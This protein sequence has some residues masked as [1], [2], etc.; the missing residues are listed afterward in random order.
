MHPEHVPGAD[1]VAWSLG[2]TTRILALGSVPLSIEMLPCCHGSA[3]LIQSATCSSLRVAAQRSCS[4]A[5]ELQPAD[6]SIQQPLKHITKEQTMQFFA[7]SVCRDEGVLDQPLDTMKRLMAQWV[8]HAGAEVE[9][10]TRITKKS[11]CHLSWTF[12]EAPMLAVRAAREH[13]TLFEEETELAEHE[14]EEE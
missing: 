4:C 10:T 7:E 2:A 3:L 8:I 9:K 6:I 5:A 1:R 11:W 13:S 12:E 14:P